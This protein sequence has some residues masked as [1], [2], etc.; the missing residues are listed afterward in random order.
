MRFPVMRDDRV[1]GLFL[2]LGLILLGCCGFVASAERKPFS[3]VEASIPDMQ[4]AMKD[5]RVTSRELVQQYLARIAT[6]NDKL[7][8]TITVNPNALKEAD[9]LRDRAKALQKAKTTGAG[10]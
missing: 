7:H 5:K 8:A 2:A 4:K 10:D 9:A 6:Y 1:R 3:V